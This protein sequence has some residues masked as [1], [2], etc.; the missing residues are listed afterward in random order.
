MDILF[1]NAMQAKLPR[2][3]FGHAPRNVLTEVQSRDRGTKTGA[4]T[5]LSKVDQITDFIKD[6]RHRDTQL[7]GMS[8]R[9]IRKR[10]N[11]V[12]AK[13]RHASAIVGYNLSNI[14]HL[15]TANANFNNRL[16]IINPNVVP[17][18]SSL[19]LAGRPLKQT[20]LG[21]KVAE[22]AVRQIP[23][24]KPKKARKERKE[25][26]KKSPDLTVMG[27]VTPAIKAWLQGSARSFNSSNDRT[28]F[29]QLISRNFKKAVRD[30]M[31][32]AMR[33]TMVE[34][35]LNRANTIDNMN[36]QWVMEYIQK[37]AEELLR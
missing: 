7:S 34:R 21:E 14:E 2:G 25:K 3:S 19:D 18:K 22:G 23:E 35:L 29:Q 6:R 30:N 9:Q 20:R 1:N 17:L 32:P 24:N 27:Q 15:R 31:P 37:R 11:R 8:L 13:N 16:N 4:P 33:D 10:H 28:S 36:R 26:E 5:D 12:Y